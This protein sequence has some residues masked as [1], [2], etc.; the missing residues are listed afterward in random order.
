MIYSMHA[1][2]DSF[3][4]APACFLHLARLQT[5]WPGCV[6][7]NDALRQRVAATL[8]RLATFMNEGGA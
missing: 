1:A 7:D 5:C 6:P 8:H 4:R 3:S 2:G